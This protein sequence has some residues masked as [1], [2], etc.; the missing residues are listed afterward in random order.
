MPISAVDVSILEPVM[1]H[2]TGIASQPVSQRYGVVLRPANTGMKIF[3][4]PARYLARFV[5]ANEMNG[6]TLITQVVPNASHIA[7]LHTGTRRKVAGLVSVAELAPSTPS[8]QD[9][10]R[11]MMASGRLRSA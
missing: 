4:L 3:Q 10:A 8:H 9:I 2:V 6:G 1:G 5:N 7:K 11:S